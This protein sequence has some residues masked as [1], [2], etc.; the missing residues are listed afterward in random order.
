MDRQNKFKLQVYREFKW[1]IRFPE[2][3]EY[4][5]GAPSRWFLKFCLPTYGLFEELGRPNK[6]VGHRSVI[7]VRLVRSQFSMF[8][9]DEHHMI[10]SD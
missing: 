4:V 2:Y 8:F 1:E 6:G 9:L 7:I 10:A 5:N 3:L